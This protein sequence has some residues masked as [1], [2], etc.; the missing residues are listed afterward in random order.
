MRRK[1]IS[2]ALVGALLCVAV[3]AMAAT[4]HGAAKTKK[5]TVTMTEFK[6]KLSK[7]SAS[8]GTVV[9]TVKNKGKVGHDFK[10]HGKKTKIVKPGKSVKLTVKFQKTGKFSYIC[11]VPGHAASGM[12]G[13]FRI[14]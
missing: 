12:K 9:F 14:K 4:H 2:A 7:S 5:I 8:K 1:A 10:I 3:P 11:T 6:F 13:T